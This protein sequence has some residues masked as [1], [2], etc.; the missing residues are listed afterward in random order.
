MND[1]SGFFGGI[2]GWNNNKKKSYY[3]SSSDEK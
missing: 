2:F 3:E 1:K